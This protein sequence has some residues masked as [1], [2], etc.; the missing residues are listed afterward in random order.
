MDCQSLLDLGDPTEGTLDELARRLAMAR[1]L[2]SL[3]TDIGDAIELDL[4]ARMEDDEVRVPHVGV[5]V[6]SREKRSSWRDSYASA[7]FRREVGQAVIKEI[8]LDIVTGELE[9]VKRNVAEATV[10]LMFD[11]I[12]AFSS[13]KARGKALG[14]HPSD[15]R[16]ESEVTRV[17]IDPE[18]SR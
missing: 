2:A 3:L 16:I 18:E 13:V 6:R 4:A 9:P 15:Y 1:I 8:A 5:L 10:A 14:V 11:V 7:E 17:T 12:P